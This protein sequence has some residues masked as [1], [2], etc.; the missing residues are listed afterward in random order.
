M[1]LLTPT[2]NYDY[3]KFCGAPGGE[4][5]RGSYYLKGKGVKGRQPQKSSITYSLQKS[6]FCLTFIRAFCGS[7]IKIFKET[8]FKYG[9]KSGSRSI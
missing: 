1:D 6:S 9:R 5:F 4:I 2:I 7:Q 8:I 3:V